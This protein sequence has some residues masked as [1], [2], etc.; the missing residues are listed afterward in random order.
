MPDFSNLVACCEMVWR[1]IQEHNADVPD[2]VVVVGSGGRRSQTLLGHFAKNTWEVDGQEMPEVLIVAEQLNRGAADIFTTLLHEAV[3]GVAHT[4]EIKDVSGKRHNKKFAV[5][6]EEVGLV[7]PESAS[8]PLGYSSATLPESTAALFGPEI[9]AIESQ[10]SFLRKIKLVQ[11]ET[12]KT[13]WIAEC[14]CDRK[15]RLPKKTIIDPDWLS[16]TCGLCSE[17]FALTEEDR[18]IFEEMFGSRV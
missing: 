4:R 13:T 3:H 11:K 14:K 6:C 2:V 8:G 15:L 7:P 17:E 9:E 1:K 5:L 16:L 10:L 18:D 12:K